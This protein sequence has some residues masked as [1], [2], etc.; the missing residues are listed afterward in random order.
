MLILIFLSLAAL[1]AVGVSRL[2]REYS[3][4]GHAISLPARSE[5]IGIAAAFVICGMWVGDSLKTTYD[6]VK[7]HPPSFLDVNGADI[8]GGAGVGVEESTMVEADKVI[9]KNARI[10]VE[11]GPTCIEDKAAWILTR[12]QPRVPVLKPDQADWI[13]FFEVLPTDPAYAGLKLESVMTLSP[14]LSIAKVQ[15]PVQP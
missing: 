2:G 8:W 7:H 1:A 5:F 13:I 9:P 10:V 14:K 11:C 15:K 3:V 12:L 6:A 4:A